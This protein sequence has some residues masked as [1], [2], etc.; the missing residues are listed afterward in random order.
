MKPVS[1]ALTLGCLA[2]VPGALADQCDVANPGDQI[3][4][5][6]VPKTSSFLPNIRLYCGADTSTDKA[7]HLE[8][9]EHNGCAKGTAVHDYVLRATTVVSD[10]VQERMNNLKLDEPA[11]V[12]EFCEHVS[13]CFYTMDQDLNLPTLN[14]EPSTFEFFSKNTLGEQ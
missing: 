5:F 3:G 2:L 10:E 1:V 9:A 11:Q 4:T 12:A 7:I 14:C 13:G 6:T 8:A